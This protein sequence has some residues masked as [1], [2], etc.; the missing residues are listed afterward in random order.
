MEGKCRWRLAHA[1][2]RGEGAVPD[3]SALFFFSIY[4]LGKRKKGRTSTV[5]VREGLSA[6]A[7]FSKADAFVCVSGL[8]RACMEDVVGKRLTAWASDSVPILEI[9]S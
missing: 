4:N 7:D 1:D 3:S 6:R 5:G 9:A 2:I 8:L